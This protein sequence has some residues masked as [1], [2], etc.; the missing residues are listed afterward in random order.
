MDREPFPEEG[1]DFVREAQGYPADAADAELARAL[2]D[3]FHEFIGDGRDHGSYRTMDGYA[4]FGEFGEG[5][6]TLRRGSR[7]GFQFGR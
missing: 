1:R 2:N 4:S 6:Q 7:T 3:V 5:G